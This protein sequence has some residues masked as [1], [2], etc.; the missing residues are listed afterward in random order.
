MLYTGDSTKKSSFSKIDKP[1]YPECLIGSSFC[2]KREVSL[3]SA[4]ALVTV[5]RF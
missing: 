4:E 2:L 3:P 5:C 1:V